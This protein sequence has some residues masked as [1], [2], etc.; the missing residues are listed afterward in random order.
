MS[1]RKHENRKRVRKIEYRPTADKRYYIFCEGKKTE[2]LYFE[3]FKRA[4]ENSAIYKHMIY[5]EVNGVGENTL[6]I[7]EAAEKAVREQNIKEARVWCVYDKDSFPAERFNGVSE[8]VAS[9]NKSQ[10]DVTYH[11]AWSNQCIEYWFILHFDFYDSDNDRK[12]YSSYLHDKFK[13]IGW[14]RYKKNDEELFT[15]L[16][17]SGNPRQAIRWAKQRLVDLSGKTDSDSVP[18]T[19][20]HELV[21]SLALYLPDELKARYL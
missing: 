17:F 6:N 1:P 12:Y 8:R 14:S 2:P 7:V 21:E 16:S 18:A 13:Q 20:V 4:I 10:N 5:I 9:L 19:K 11:V 3:G 15:R